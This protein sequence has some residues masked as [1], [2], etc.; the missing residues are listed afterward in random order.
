MSSPPTMLGAGLLRF[1]D[2][3]AGRDDA[4][5]LGF[6]KTVRKNHRAAHHLIGVLGIDSQTHVQLQPSH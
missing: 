6:P 2:L 5:L 4:N 3:V 1:L